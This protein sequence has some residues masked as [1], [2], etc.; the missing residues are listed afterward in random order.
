MI[1]DLMRSHR[2][3][4][5]SID[6]VTEKLA[7]DHSREAPM[8]YSDMSGLFAFSPALLDLTI[9]VLIAFLTSYTDRLPAFQSSIVMSQHIHHM[10]NLPFKFLFVIEIHR[11]EDMSSQSV[12]KFQSCQHLGWL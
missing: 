10:K 12:L 11:E 5:T 3:A 6:I 2:M 1:G 4:T 7:Y 9:M 8:Q